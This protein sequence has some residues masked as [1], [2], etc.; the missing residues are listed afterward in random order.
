MAMRLRAC[1]LLVL[2]LT[3]CATSATGPSAPIAPDPRLANLQ[4]AASL[5]WTDEGRCVVREASQSWPVLVE[6]CYPVLDRDRLTFH[7]FSG[8]CAVASAGA[9]AVGF[10]LCVLA[11]P[12]L[13]LGA[14]AVAGGVVVGFALH[15]ALDVYALSREPT[16]E[17]PVSEGASAPRQPSPDRQSQPQP[18]GP[19]F[20]PPGVMD[21]T[22]DPHR[23]ECTP[24]RVRHRGG[25][26][27]HNLCA[28]RIPNNTFSGGDVRV[29][30]KNFD[31]LQGAIRTLWEVK[32]NDIATYNAFVR[33]SELAKQVEE[34][35]NERALAMACGFRFSIG[36]RS[37]VHQKLLEELLPGFDIVLMTWC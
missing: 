6:R 33:R 19:D 26:A 31:A 34:A 2:C 21:V 5:P 7:D 29:N 4:R 10:G 17:R 20:P 24:R 11:A 27:L 22:E 14:V 15:E 16:R 18:R 25:N 13:V 8:R 1:T 32:T 12:E 36:V 9:A 3:A 28:D 37:E 30:G 35:K 23:P